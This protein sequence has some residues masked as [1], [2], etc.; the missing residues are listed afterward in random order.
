IQLKEL[1]DKYEKI[2]LEG[3]LSLNIRLPNHLV[4]ATEY[5]PE[6]IGLINEL[7][8][9]GIAYAAKDGVYVRIEK[10][11]N[12]G[13]LAHLDLTG[14]SNSKTDQKTKLVNRERV[15][16][17]EYDKTDPRDFA[18][19]KFKTEED[20][21]IFWETPFGT[22]RPGWHIECSAM[23]M[24]LLGPTIDIHTGAI[25]L[26]FPHH[27]NEIA[28]SE[29]VTGKR[30]VNYWMHGAFM[31]INEE[32][33]AKSKNNF[34][35]LDD[36][37]AETISP[38]AF[39]YWLLTSHYRSPVNFSYTAVRGAQN[40]LIRL[41]SLIG[42]YPEG[43]SV[44]AEYK[45]RFNAFVNDD[46]DTPQ[47]VALAWELTKDGKISDADK[48]ATL[49]DFDKVF[50]LKFDS[51]KLKAFEAIPPEIQALADAREEARRKKDWKQADALRAEIE[52]RGFA[53]DDTPEGIKISER[54]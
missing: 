37:A 6:M 40:A 7:I 15:V 52:S 46:L 49:I 34:F 42:S 41:M 17:D 20:G 30:F 12:Y 35:K 45:K 21:D 27:T 54:E 50:G 5:I 2:F 10:V 8:K 22:G 53:I 38:L 3:L 9:K 32:K 43:G 26:I 14:T 29:S 4:H 23:S 44:V 16:N 24:K 13:E 48:R 18:L 47:A 39:R 11:K 25:D 28:Q 36:L 1:T 31:N 51:V 19:W 33:M